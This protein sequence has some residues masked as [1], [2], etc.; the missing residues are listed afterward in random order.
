MPFERYIPSI[1]MQLTAALLLLGVSCV[2]EDELIANVGDFEDDTVSIVAT[3]APDEQTRAENGGLYIDEGIVNRGTFYL[4]FS[5]SGRSSTSTNEYKSRAIVEF[6]LPEDPT[7]GYAYNLK[8]DKTRKDLKW[9]SIYNSG[10]STTDFQLT[11]I[12]PELYNVR[13]STSASTSVGTVYRYSN[14]FRFINATNPY[15]ARPLDEVNGTN[16]ILFGQVSKSVSSTTAS[17]KIQFDNLYHALSLLQ[18]VI[19]VHP[20]E[21]GQELTLSLDNA[22]I[23]ISWVDK[24]VGSFNC[25]SSY[26]SS[27]SHLGSSNGSIIDLS[28]SN[29]YYRYQGYTMGAE[30]G[31]PLVLVD[32]DTDRNKA[33]QADEEDQYK[34]SVWE[35]IEK[36]DNVL[37]YTTKRFV[38]P[39]Q[40]LPPTTSV[41]KPELLVTVPKSDM[42]NTGEG[43]IT[44]HGYLPGDMY[45]LNGT[46]KT[47]ALISGTQLTI[48]AKINSPDPE[49]TFSPVKVEPWVSK[50]TFEF[51][52]RQA[53][54]YN[55]NDFKALL[56]LYDDLQNGDEQTKKLAEHNLEKYGYRGE[57]GELIFQL[58]GNLT[59]YEDKIKE[60]MRVIEGVTPDFSFMFNGFTVTTVKK[61]ETTGGG[62]GGGDGT[63]QP[64]DTEIAPSE[65]DVKAGKVENIDGGT[66]DAMRLF[67]F[68]NLLTG[69]TTTEP[70]GINNEKDFWD[71]VE[72]L[73]SDTPKITDIMKYGVL[74]NID[75][76]MTFDI[77]A[78]FEIDKDEFEKI[79][80]KIPEKLWEYKIQ[81]TI[82]EGKQVT[83]Q[84]PAKSRKKDNGEGGDP[85]G[86][87]GDGEI[88]E[89]KPYEIKCVPGYCP[90]NRLT[91]KRTYGVATAEDFYF[92]ADW[93]TNCYYI[94]PD[95]FELFGS[96]TTIYFRSAMTLE[97]SRAYLSMLP[98]TS[99][100]TD[101]PV[102]RPNYNVSCSGTI[103]IE[104]ELVPASTS[105]N[106]YLKPMLFGAVANSNT[107]LSSI[108]SHY[109]NNSFNQ[110]NYYYLWYYGRFDFDKEHDGANPKWIFPLQY[111]TNSSYVTYATLFDQMHA[112]PEGGKYDYEFELDEAKGYFYVTDMPVPDEA[113][114]KTDE[115]KPHYFYQTDDEAHAHYYGYPNTAAEL[116][117]VA[118]GTYWEW[119]QQ[120]YTEHPKPEPEPD[121]QP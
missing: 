52:M 85:G 21:K 53:G 41:T 3:V 12:P 91:S 75:E 57:N 105:T 70:L 30:D 62:E 59:L 97:G 73:C 87:A 24:V 95:L 79:Y 50:S 17:R 81:F 82:H 89:E 22:K 121:P 88:E 71:V 10:A 25:Y 78:T 116:K 56:D 28:T 64:E 9:S 100:K 31:K 113:G 29:D 42:G 46:P 111:G 68:Y 20:S 8:A 102:Y 44:Y 7:T 76:L 19:E 119:L 110:I 104:D 35:S 27:F 96:S 51:N 65:D 69:K 36:K 80:R 107:S 103:T 114:N 60:K 1:R 58:W 37:V 4:F 38:M 40:N 98:N 2:K 55:A 15:F 101:D 54:I 67:D 14:Y 86:D 72:I 32:P 90:L 120:W 45:D 83:I 33:L 43:T 47:T 109:N 117:K 115:K 66:Y 49:L 77:N 23:E 18:V 16:D 118:D 11:N 63:E 74:S 92:M 48:R 108:V 61:K 26:Y 93:Y 5:P 34:Y 39:P 84:I 94:N 13:T 6:G 99:V 112:V 106:T